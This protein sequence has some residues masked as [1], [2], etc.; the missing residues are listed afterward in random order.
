M[1]EQK[2]PESQISAHAAAESTDITIGI[3]NRTS[4]STITSPCSTGGIG[5]APVESEP[6]PVQAKSA[7]PAESA[8]A[9]RILFLPLSWSRRYDNFAILSQPYPLQSF[10]YLRI[11]SPAPSQDDPRLL[12]CRQLARVATVD[13]A[14]GGASKS[15]VAGFY[16]LQ[17]LRGSGSS[18]RSILAASFGALGSGQSS[19]VAQA[20]WVESAP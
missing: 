4:T 10:F 2:Q 9:G 8:S 12:D 20:C 13:S 18:V 11:L 16:M 19:H 15:R 7:S 5:S 17:G 14:D 6:A 3:I 1:D